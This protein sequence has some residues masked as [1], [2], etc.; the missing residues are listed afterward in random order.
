ML[1]RF[2]QFLGSVIV[3]FFLNA[4]VGAQTITLLC[5]APNGQHARVFK[6]DFAARTV[7]GWKAEITDGEI[8]WQSS[9]PATKNNPDHNTINRYNGS[10]STWYGGQLASA[11]QPAVTCAKAPEQK[12]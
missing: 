8:K 6:V 11:P 7:D 12:F 4:S 3:V 2:G 1:R 9:I 5:A 10:F